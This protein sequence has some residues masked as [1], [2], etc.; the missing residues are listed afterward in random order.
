VKRLIKGYTVVVA[1]VG[2][3]LASG[4][5]PAL[6]GTEAGDA[7]IKV[8]SIGTSVELLQNFHSE[9]V[10]A[11]KNALTTNGATV[12]Q[13]TYDD[14]GVNNDIMVMEWVDVQHSDWVRIKPMHTYT[15]DGNV[16]ND[17]CLAVLNASFALNQPIVNATCTYD[18]IDNDVWHAEYV[19]DAL[20]HALYQFRNQRS[21]LC[22]VVQSASAAENAPL[23]QYTCNGTSNSYW[24]RYVL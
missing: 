5:S 15:G 20:G 23:V 19:N 7:P 4:A 2:T 17:K 16:H 14:N 22:L 13:H 18:D 9:K 6:A 24:Y 11:V 12:L 8:A 3:V 10:V 1:V 21:N